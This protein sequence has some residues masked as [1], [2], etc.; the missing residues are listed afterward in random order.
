MSNFSH[1]DS[2]EALDIISQK[3]KKIA[4]LKRQLEEVKARNVGLEICVKNQDSAVRK[5]ESLVSPRST[6]SS[7]TV[8]TQEIEDVIDDVYRKIKRM[9]DIEKQLNG[10]RKGLEK[11]SKL[12]L[13]G[14][15]EINE[16]KGHEKSKTMEKRMHGKVEKIDENGAQKTKQGLDG[17]VRKAEGE[18]SASERAFRQVAREQPVD[19]RILNTRLEQLR[20]ERDNLLDIVKHYEPMIEQR[21]TEG[22]QKQRNVHG[23]KKFEV[24]ATLTVEDKIN[25]E[26]EK[27]ELLY[28]IDELK[29]CLE[30]IKKKKAKKKQTEKDRRQHPV[31]FNELKQR[32][33]QLEAK[34]RSVDGQWPYNQLHTNEMTGPHGRGEAG[35]TMNQSELKGG[36]NWKTNENTRDRERVWLPDR[37]FGYCQKEWHENPNEGKVDCSG[38]RRRSLVAERPGVL[39][40][41]E[42]GE[43]NYVTKVLS[44]RIQELELEEKKKND[45]L[46]DLQRKLDVAEKA[47]EELTN[48]NESITQQ[49]KEL[50]HL[51]TSLEA[52]R[53][54]N[55]RQFAKRLT[56]EADLGKELE[57]CI[58]EMV[59]ETSSVKATADD[60]DKKYSNTLKKLD[61]LNGE[62]DELEKTVSDLNNKDV[63][64]GAR[65]KDLEIKANQAQEEMEKLE[66]YVE[67]SQNKVENLGSSLERCEA[68]LQSERENS[69]VFKS[70]IQQSEKTKENLENELQTM[71]SKHEKLNGAFSNLEDNLG[72]EK[73]L[74]KELRDKEKQ[75]E[76]EITGLRL[77]KD[78][79]LKELED[80][81]QTLTRTQQDLLGALKYKPLLSD[82]KE[83]ILAL[84]KNEAKLEKRIADA[85]SKLED[86]LH[87]SE[88]L[89]TEAKENE[90]ETEKLKAEVDCLKQEK[91]KLNDAIGGMEKDIVNQK[92]K[93][94]QRENEVKNLQIK[95]NERNGELIQNQKEL[96]KEREKVNMQNKEL[97]EKTEMIQK[98]Q[99]ETDE[100][101]NKNNTLQK[102]VESMK[103]DKKLLGDKVDEGNKEL[104]F[105]NMEL[106][107][108]GNLSHA[109]ESEKSD[110]LEKVQNE[111]EA[112]SELQKSKEKLMREIKLLDSE[113]K[114][115]QQNGLKKERQ[116]MEAEKL[117]NDKS[118]IVNELVDDVKSLE[119]KKTKLDAKI[120]TANFEYANLEEENKELKEQIRLS[121]NEFSGI[122][123]SLEKAWKEKENIQ[124]ILGKHIDENK[125]LH[126]EVK[127]LNNVSEMKENKIE[128]LG[129]EN[130]ECRVNISSLE[131]NIN[132]L[133]GDLQ[134]M[135]EKLRARDEKALQ[136][137]KKIIDREE[138]LA[139]FYEK[140][141]SLLENIAK[142]NEEIDDLRRK[143]K[144]LKDVTVDRN[145][146]IERLRSAAEKLETKYQVEVREKD[147]KWQL[148][149]EYNKSLRKQV[150][151]FKER[152]KRFLENGNVM[153]VQVNKLTD[154]L[155]QAK[156]ILK[157]F[158]VTLMDKDNDLKKI[159]EA[160]MLLENAYAT[161]QAGLQKQMRE[162]QNELEAVTKK[163]SD[164]E[165]RLTLKED[166]A[167]RLQNEIDN[168]V[169][170]LKNEE[171]VI[172]QMEEDNERLEDSILRIK[173]ALV[174]GGQKLGKKEN[175]VNELRSK[176]VHDG[177]EVEDLI[178]E[179]ETTLKNVREQLLFV[180][181]EKAKMMEVMQDD[182]MKIEELEMNVNEMKQEIQQ[183]NEDL[184]LE[185]AKR[186]DLQ[187]QIEDKS[188]EKEDRKMIEELKTELFKVGRE[189]QFAVV[190]LTKERDDALLERTAEKLA[191]DNLK[192]QMK[193][194]KDEIMNLKK[195]KDQKSNEQD[196]YAIELKRM[197][198]ESREREKD[199]VAREGDYKLKLKEMSGTVRALEGRIED[200]VTQAE[201]EKKKR[202][203]ILAQLLKPLEAVEEEIKNKDSSD[204]DKWKKRA[205]S[206]QSN[207]DDL[208]EQFLKYRNKTIADND[209]VKVRINNAKDEQIARLK[210]DLEEAEKGRALMQRRFNELRSELASLDNKRLKSKQDNNKL[211]EELRL[212]K[213]EAMIQ[214]HELD[215]LRHAVGKSGKQSVK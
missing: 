84:H 30:D 77:E 208:R 210:L 191:K 174:E 127:H 7:D 73:K 81:R 200:A 193:N 15:I 11:G 133:K 112:N 56:D 16:S 213:Q 198:A 1:D 144:D 102:E 97:K 17:P 172:I 23:S 196:R 12:S 79:S 90:K 40:D 159:N 132:F 106:K 29:K 204:S 156:I 82:A 176:L 187:K 33:D 153:K 119:E 21:Y 190:K 137:E 91:R 186:N 128:E 180:E 62:K 41:N 61:D 88:E 75:L 189:K 209:A 13:K 136:M 202:E 72:K 14:D 86:A 181:N 65:I 173:R 18:I 60:L 152:E 165:K 123:R 215:W 92:A 95:V 160:V 138:K 126:E 28:H 178:G 110:L 66:K 4:D 125:F 99:K 147:Q 211:A 118:N 48:R 51:C 55:S 45:K 2:Q 6:A 42:A 149:D 148:F 43:G 26:R 67:M 46:Y 59:K 214:K 179:L 163:N 49:M 104:R 108:L 78:L 197:L 47:S 177:R 195:R 124:Q 122:Q 131:N 71:K 146:E 19:N 80:M 105:L 182:E 100:I 98:M 168:L 70:M 111:A 37:Q 212:A 167:D 194:M 139:K 22:G 3:D 53:S 164:L 130:Q 114:S 199:A 63:K 20:E 85:N 170:R 192:V 74:A 58:K 69:V 34:N 27:Q 54:M 162:I 115:E 107:S 203:E 175:E 44:D 24:E 184:M 135:R 38:Q 9:E 87:D 101:K 116:L 188:K 39:N 201:E 140:N 207:I 155:K 96:G 117:I 103:Y 183:K 109:L 121:K 120:I 161:R 35:K 94:S 32:I 141:N 157:D 171:Q 83:K 10:S 89:K 8:G 113:L 142:K 134:D 93:I 57:S 150:D 76:Q 5:I 36:S 185:K 158:Q 169:R 151:G 205:V 64:S 166:E 129:Q 143:N 31:D 25:S 154:E 68:D 50:V 145:S 206:L 52:D